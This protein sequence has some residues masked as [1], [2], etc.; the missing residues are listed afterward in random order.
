MNP[1]SDSTP[2]RAAETPAYTRLPGVGGFIFF[3]TR[4]Y[5]GPDHLMMVNT[6]GF[7]E[8]YKR[9]FFQDIQAVVLHKSITGKILNIILII[10]SCLSLMGALQMG[11]NSDGIVL[12][13]ISGCLIIITLFHL[14]SGPTCVTQL[15]TATGTTWLRSVNRLR[16]AERLLQTI[17]PLVE[18]AQ[19]EP[20]PSTFAADRVRPGPDLNPEEPSDDRPAPAE[21]SQP[22]P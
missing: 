1:P 8:D 13:A 4:L 11:F 3:Y 19:A 22:Q 10:I 16:K 2:P 15:Q 7:S 12:S 9:F 18:Q 14:I 5:Q 20:A 6:N 21:H 17:R